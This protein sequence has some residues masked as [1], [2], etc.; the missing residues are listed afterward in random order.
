MWQLYYICPF[1]IGEHAEWTKQQLFNIAN[2]VPFM[3]KVPGVTD[4]GLKTDKLVELV[5]LMPT[6]V[7]AAGFHPLKTCPENSHHVQ[8]CTEGA[9]LM[10]LMTDQNSDDWKDAVFW[11]MPQKGFTDD[12]LPTKMGYS[13]RTDEYRYTEYVD[14]KY[15]EKGDYAPDWEAPCDHE[16]LYDLTIDPQETWNR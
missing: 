16:E 6:L 11:Q 3:V 4:T 13:I 12:E 9:S 5:D 15:P 14:I 8:L 1:L 10:P 7:E 2:R